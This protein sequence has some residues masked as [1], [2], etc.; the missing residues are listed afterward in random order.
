MKT[1]PWILGLGVMGFV[2]T[3]ALEYFD[4]GGMFSPYNLN[5]TM[6][7]DEVQAIAAFKLAI[8]EVNADPNI[9]P[10]YTVRGSFQ[11]ITNTASA[12]SATLALSKTAFGSGVDITMRTLNT[13][14]SIIAIEIFAV[15]VLP[16]MVL[17]DMD[18][19]LSL[20][21]SYPYHLRIVPSTSYEVAI[22]S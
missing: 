10:G 16:H 7:A 14:R 11:S 17:S 6:N 3:Y 18:S 8:D 12:V 19:S 4:I 5:G 9:L 22:H 13:P 15:Y 1:S 2:R 20:A 21:A